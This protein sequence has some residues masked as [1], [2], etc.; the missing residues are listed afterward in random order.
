MA[1]RPA[2]DPVAIRLA[3]LQEAILTYCAIQIMLEHNEGIDTA[4]ATVMDV[5]ER[6]V[7]EKRE[8]RSV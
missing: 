3:E 4:V 7:V 5:M 8:A 2:P 1:Q 6:I